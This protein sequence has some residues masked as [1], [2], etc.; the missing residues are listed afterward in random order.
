MRIKPDEIWK[1]SA[2]LV[3]ASDNDTTLKGYPGVPGVL[4][5]CQPYSP[6]P[7]DLDL[8]YLKTA[9]ENLETSRKQISDVISQWKKA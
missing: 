1:L 2:D 6:E 7:Y 3:V 9:L 5:T 8:V 4:G